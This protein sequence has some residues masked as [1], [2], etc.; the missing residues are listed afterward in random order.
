MQFI[1][2]NPLYTWPSPEAL[3]HDLF[4]FQI[5]SLIIVQ[6]MIILPRRPFSTITALFE[7]S[8]LISPCTAGP[9]LLQNDMICP[10]RLPIL[11]RA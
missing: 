4:L 10:L 5:I 2:F 3:T 6:I 11:V 7:P 9:L 8:L 1:E